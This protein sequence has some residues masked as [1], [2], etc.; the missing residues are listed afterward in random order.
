MNPYISVENLS[1][2]YKQNHALKGVNF[3]ADKGE[4][5]AI[6]GKSGSGKTTFLQALA[7]F[8]PSTGKIL[9]PQTV[10]V[11]FQQYAVFPWLTV[12]EN[13]GFGLENHSFEER[14]QII[15]A[16]LALTQLTD[17]KDSYPAELSGGQVQRV[18]LARCL[19][20]NSE[21]LLMDEPYGALDAYTRE[22]MQQWLLDVWSV[23]EKTIIFVT[24][25]IEEAIFL[26][27]RVLV[28]KD[29]QFIKESKIDFNRPR[30][31]EIKFAT[32]FSNLRREISGQL[33]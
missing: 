28:L 30:N 33:N 1:V 25:D 9:I 15:R 20:H 21:V 11:V 3:A 7:N 23:N 4:F 24:H 10:G 18:A 5:V 26:A 13:I 29:G 32:E 12:A 8:V 16:H 31:P 14:Q 27:D 2:N 17:K 6:V 22:K 19:A